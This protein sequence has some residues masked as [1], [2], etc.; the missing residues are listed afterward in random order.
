MST[1]FEHPTVIQHE[2]DL[3]MFELAW[4]LCYVGAEPILSIAS[5]SARQLAGKWNHT[6]FQ[7]P[8]RSRT[9]G[10]GDFLS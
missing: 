6:A 3:P 9:S 2:G 4:W 7:P 5:R 8:T 1:V 10:R